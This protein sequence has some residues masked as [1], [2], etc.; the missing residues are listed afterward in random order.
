MIENEFSHN[1]LISGQGIQK[2]CRIQ[3]KLLLTSINSSVGTLIYSSILSKPNAPFHATF[4]HYEKSGLHLLEHDMSQ[5]DSIM[6]FEP[7]YLIPFRYP[8]RQTLLA[9]PTPHHYRSL[10]PPQL[11]LI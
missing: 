3:T 5:M 4:D 11:H 6:V 9:Q 2:V 1:S 10:P 7:F 8:L